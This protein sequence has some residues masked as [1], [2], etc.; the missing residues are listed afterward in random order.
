MSDTTLYSTPRETSIN[1]GSFIM[2]II[3]NGKGINNEICNE[4]FRY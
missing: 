1:E 2:E 4:Y 3:N